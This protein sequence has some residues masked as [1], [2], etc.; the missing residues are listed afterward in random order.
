MAEAH[1]VLDRL[2]V[3]NRG[4]AVLDN[5]SLSVVRG[6]TLA[7]LGPQ[8]CGKTATLL[9]IA[10]FL[11]PSLGSIR[12]AGRD[13]T[14]AA[15]ETRNVA[16][17]PDDDAL[18]PHLSVLDNVAFGLKMRGVA[19]DERRAQAAAM[20][21]ALGAGHLA[22]RSPARLDPPERRL[23]SLA[24]A[25]ATHPALLLVDEPAAP[26][27][28]DRR[29]AA[30]AVLGAALG[31]EHTTAILATHDRAAAFGLAGRVALL[32]D[33]RLEQLGTPQ[34]LY[35]HPA[36]RFVAGFTGGCNLL[37]A[38]LLHERDGE[39]VISV[40]GQ[41]ANARCA[42]GTPAGVMTL[43]L[44]PNRL[45]LEPGSPLRGLVE[46]LAYQGAVTRATLR[47]GGETAVAEITHA[48]PGL[49][50]G[51]EVGIGWNTADSWLIAGGAA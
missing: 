2:T 27:D 6:E 1:L 38:T 45:R 32:R 31:P 49:A 3:R 47:L 34:D 7:L 35:E 29:E 14:V 9:A 16:L 51:S 44:R 30:R 12:L 22:A 42:P 28:A 13:I 18:F 17:A 4:R 8:G 46:S 10:G 25:A 40:A 24:R 23:V 36:T 39:A 21:S 26:E 11:R 37:R 5:L 48:P 20:L 43:C 33:G 41:T 19:R 15:P 50:V